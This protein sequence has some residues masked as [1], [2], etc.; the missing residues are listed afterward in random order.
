MKPLEIPL[1][2]PS[3][4]KTLA[5]AKSHYAVYARSKRAGTT[6]VEVLARAGRYPMATGPV[7][8]RFDWYPKD[9]REDLDNV[10]SSVK[11]ILDG[12]VQAGVLPDDSQRWV[13]GLDHRLHDPDKARPRVVVTWEPAV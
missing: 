12:M 10:A 8:L 4:N 6:M 7:C 5:M 13:R 11:V 3:L 1:P 2:L 9:R